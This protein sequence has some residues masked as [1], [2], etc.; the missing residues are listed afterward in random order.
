MDFQLSTS[1]LSAIIQDQQSRSSRASL[2]R[3]L[4]D[5]ALYLGQLLN[6]V[7]STLKTTKL[8]FSRWQ[9]KLSTYNIRTMNIPY[10][11]TKIT[12][13]LSE[14]VMTFICQ[15][16]VTIIQTA[17]VLWDIILNSLK[18]LHTILTFQ[19]TTSQDSINLK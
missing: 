14:A 7:I 10:V 15:I 4:G 8:L 11:T 16:I 17:I 13:L 6:Q 2:E 3:C 9:I 18:D 12:C 19:R 5:T 1:I